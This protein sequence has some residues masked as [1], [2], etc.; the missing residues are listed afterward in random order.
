MPPALPINRKP[1]LHPTVPNKVNNHS[2]AQNE[3][4][5]VDN[6]IINSKLSSV[7]TNSRH[8]RNNNTHP[9]GYNNMG[10]GGY[11]GGYGMGMGMGMG[12]MGMGGGYQMAGPMN[13]IYSVNYFIAMVSQIMMMI[14]MNSQAITQIFYQ[15]STVLS[16]F[17]VTV[18][19]SS[20]RRWIQRKSKQSKI[21]RFIFVFCS[22]LIASQAY[23][24]IK[25]GI[26][27]YFIGDKTLESPK[28]ERKDSPS[29]LNTEH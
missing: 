22:M 14:G 26:G 23:R 25:F 15:L 4:M 20:F 21:L 12:M 3:S 18:R 7:A 28:L 24:L 1:L 6:S 9:I 10:Y 13:L 11:G 16:E 2:M 17:E 19:K 8:I 29:L 5:P 27:Q